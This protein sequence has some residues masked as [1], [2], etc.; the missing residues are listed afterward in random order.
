[1]NLKRAIKG[2]V[3]DTRVS[4]KSIVSDF[5]LAPSKVLGELNQFL[6]K[7]E[8]KEFLEHCD[9]AFDLAENLND[10]DLVAYANDQLG[11]GFD[12]LLSEY[13]AYAS[14]DEINAFIDHFKRMY[15]IEDSAMTPAARLLKFLAEE[16]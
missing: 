6:S 1:M 4:I 2:K 7:D 9:T 3:V 16:E 8:K 13:D 10:G 12:Y 15:S 11:G 5:E 14:S